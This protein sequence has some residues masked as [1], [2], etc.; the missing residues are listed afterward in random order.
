M[1]EKHGAGQKESRW[2]GLIFA[3]DVET[4]VTTARLEDSNL[5]AH[6][7]ARND[8]W[9][10]HKSGSDVG[11]DTKTL[12]GSEVKHNDS[13][14]NRLPSVKVGHDHDIELLWFRD[15]LHG[16]I[17]DNH[18][19]G[20]DGRKLFAKANEKANLAMRSDLARVMILSDS[21]TPVTD[22]CSRPE[23]SP[24]VFSR[25]MHRSTSLCRVCRPGMFLQSVTEA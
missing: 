19:V 25:M 7:A 1:A 14:G 23:Y 11:Q 15:C 17:V 22:W 24:S 16:G 12:L 21:T 8:T 10:T 6:V 4:N 2:I 3:F 13:K 20:S 9:S 18:V 5:S